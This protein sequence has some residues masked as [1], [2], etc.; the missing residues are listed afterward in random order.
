MADPEVGLVRSQLDRLNESAS[1]NNLGNSETPPPLSPRSGGNSEGSISPWDKEE[2]QEVDEEGDE[3]EAWPIT[4][5]YLTFETELPQPTSITPRTSDAPLPSGPPDL[6]KF[7]SPFLWP[8]AHK[9]IIIWIS[10]IATAFTAFAAGAYSPGQQQMKDEWQVSTVA[11]LCGITTFTT[12][13]GIAPMVLAPFSEINGRV[14]L[15]SRLA[16]NHRADYF[17]ETS[18]Y[19]FRFTLCAL[20]ALLRTHPYIRWHARRTVLRRGRRLNIQHYGRRCDF[21]Y[22]PYG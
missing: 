9:R 22:L 2:Y 4:Y 17:V 10:V 15:V 3:D 8:D 6:T 7:T 20:S 14:S 11:I 18:V 13:F 12:G 21:R 19:C 16:D 5:Q 1:G